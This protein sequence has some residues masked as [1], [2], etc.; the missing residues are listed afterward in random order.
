MP[1]RY[2]FFF[3]NENFWLSVFIY[4][5]VYH[6]QRVAISI[7]DN[8][9]VLIDPDEAVLLCVFLFRPADLIGG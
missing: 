9:L 4:I 2:V 3:E 5:R 6:R 7:V 1:S 8:H